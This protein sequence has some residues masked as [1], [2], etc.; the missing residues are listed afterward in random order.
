MTGADRAELEN[1][2]VR[3][4]R[5]E[6]FS[7]VNVE[8][9]VEENEVRRPEYARVREHNRCRSEYAN[10]LKTLEVKLKQAERQTLARLNE[11]ESCRGQRQRDRDRSSGLKITQR[12][13]C[14]EA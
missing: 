14:F 10:C 8:E 7:G 4:D 5:V 3:T 2:L 6:T 11:T 1:V 12:R 13:I 9:E